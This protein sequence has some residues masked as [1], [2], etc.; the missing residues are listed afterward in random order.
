MEAKP[1]FSIVIPAYNREQEIRRAIRSCLSQD[2]VDFEALVVDDGSIDGTG[3]A[4]L[5]E[6]DARVRLITHAINRGV[7]PARNSGVRESR[8]GWIVFLDSDHEMLPRCLSRAYSVA[9]GLPEEIGR[10]GFLYCFDSGGESPSPLPEQQ[11]LDYEQW[12]KWIENAQRSD[13]LWFVRRATFAECMLPE[14]Y[15]LEFS[16]WLDFTKRYGTRIIP[17][18]GAIEHTDSAER[19]S[20]AGLPTNRQ[21]MIQQARDRAEDWGRVLAE[22]G[23][24][25]RRTAPRCHGTVLRAACLAS[26]LAGWRLEGIRAGGA[27]LRTRPFSPLSWA[28]L[29]L[30]LAGTGPTRWALG[31]RRRP[32]ARASRFLPA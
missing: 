26:L 14:S 5:Q 6:S 32:K 9:G 20:E 15:A 16:Y 24:A 18:I 4:V 2:F 13:A 1:Y 12:L 22:H 11:D 29:A 19:L 17:E 21:L 27:G 23:D 10:F 7:C 3:A 25:L 28:A 31:L 8:A 30:S